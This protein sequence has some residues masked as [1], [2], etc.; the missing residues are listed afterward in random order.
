MTSKANS[1]FPAQISR[2]EFEKFLAG[3]EKACGEE[4]VVIVRTY[5]GYQEGRAFCL[6]M[7]PN[8]EAVRRA[9]ER[10]GLAF[11]SI[12]EVETASPNDTFFE[13]TPPGE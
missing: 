1:T 2:D 5:V 8:A 10:V 12:T 4:G 11:D 13:R 9:H 7:A 6:T 3:Y